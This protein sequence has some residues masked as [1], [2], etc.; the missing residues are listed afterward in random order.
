METAGRPLGRDRIAIAAS[1]ALHL[2]AVIALGTLPRASFPVD[3]PDERLLLTSQIRVE[4]RPP[5]RAVLV[6]RALAP[7][8]DTARPAVRPVIHTAVT[9]E[10]A[11]RRLVVAPEAPNAYAPSASASA[12]AEAPRE[13][14]PGVAPPRL[15]AAAATTE[16]V[17]AS[18]APPAPPSPAPTAAAQVDEG[19][20]NFGETY[21]ASIEPTLRSAL[22]AVGSGF[23]VRVTVD[24]NGHA[25]SIE[26]MRAPPDPTLREALRVK[27]LA[28]RFIPADCNGLRCAGTVELRT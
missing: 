22:A 16:A 4:H 11:T 14:D 19:V 10:H 12:I 8:A 24:E 23:V 21:P 17:E 20:G 18:P 5:A 28:A 3:D 25:T 26:F 27:L 13:A 15:L 6:R 9:V 2:C 7:R 1:I